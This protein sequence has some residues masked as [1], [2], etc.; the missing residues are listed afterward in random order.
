LKFSGGVQYLI[1]VDRLGSVSTRA[2]IMIVRQLQV[3]TVVLDDS[4][5]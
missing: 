5:R 1:Q 4:D 2:K 3:E